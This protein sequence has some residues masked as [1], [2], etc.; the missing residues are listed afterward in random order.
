MKNKGVFQEITTSK[1]QKLDINN[2]LSE[3]TETD[4]IILGSLLESY[5]NDVE[6]CFSWDLPN[7]IQQH[8]PSPKL[9]LA[10]VK[11]LRVGLIEK[12]NVSDFNGNEC[13]TYR[14]TDYA[15]DICLKNEDKIAELFALKP[16]Q[17]FVLQ[18]PKF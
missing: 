7:K 4:L 3:V 6:G 10:I 2:L 17:S 13:F 15:V 14:L 16:Q 11:L 9:N 18:T 12:E 5:N 8:I 1:V